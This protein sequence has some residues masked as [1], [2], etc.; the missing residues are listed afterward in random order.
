METEI[1]EDCQGLVSFVPS[2]LGWPDREPLL[3]LDS[4]QYYNAEIIPDVVPI[5]SQSDQPEISLKEWLY[6][7]R[8][9]QH[10]LI[11]IVRTTQAMKTSIDTTAKSDLYHYRGLALTELHSSLPSAAK[12]CY[13][14]VLTF[15]LLLM[16]AE[17]QL[18]ATQAWSAHLDAVRRIISLRGGFERCF[19]YLLEDRGSLVNYLAIDILST[20]TTNVLLLTQEIVEAQAE[21]LPGLPHKEKDIIANCCPCPQILLQAII[22]TN[23]LRVRCQE[24]SSA[25]DKQSSYAIDVKDIIHTVIAFNAEFWAEV[26][27]SNLTNPVPEAAI[28]AW[29]SLALCY[30]SAT[31]VYI[32]LSSPVQ[33]SL[34]YEDIGSLVVS[35]KHALTTHI[36]TLFDLASHSHTAPIQSQLWKF[37]IWPLVISAYVR[38][39]FDLGDESIDFEIHRLETTA[40]ALG[41]RSLSD[42]AKLMRGIGKR[43]ALEK[44][45]GMVR[46]WRWDDG[47][48]TR[49]VFVI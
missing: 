30:K 44:D 1:S 22:R 39:A 29:A 32:L 16:M 47:W 33:P 18:S 43:R 17:I 11:V 38:I 26:P 41:A 28:A 31:L 36:H 20:T 45:M 5:Y 4:I 13:A 3:L 6:L 27:C 10:L 23:I 14:V 8:L 37:I 15:T 35:A 7:P 2:S 34:P 9:L 48:E 21:Y 19:R 42:A 24:V 25:M 40:V 49:C 46:E 12:D